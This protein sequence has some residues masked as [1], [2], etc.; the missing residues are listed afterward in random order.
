MPPGS[1]G[2]GLEGTA[3]PEPAAHRPGRQLYLGG[4]QRHTTKKAPGRGTARVRPCAPRMSRG[5][6][7]CPGLIRVVFTGGVGSL[8][9]QRLQIT[10][11]KCR[12][13]PLGWFPT[14]DKKCIKQNLSRNKPKCEGASSAR[15][16]GKPRA[17]PC[18]RSV[19][20]KVAAVQATS[21]SPPPIAFS[22]QLLEGIVPSLSV[23]PA[24]PA[25]AWGLQ[26]PA[27]SRAAVTAPGDDL[28]CPGAPA[29][30]PLSFCPAKVRGRGARPGSDNEAE[31]GGV[32]L[33]DLHCPLVPA[34][35][36]M[37][38]PRLQ[39]ISRWPQRP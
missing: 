39:E 3:G 38:L 8:V 18:P 34:R 5:E 2:P 15:P 12:P 36:G 33:G 10:F 16:A 17:R 1:A 20:S 19:Q 37:C 23:G 7:P 13:L 24:P 27:Q 28:P 9:F 30:F 25:I 21:F 14:R 22:P 11:P 26:G 4:E 29:F 31:P 32:S 35:H 6:A